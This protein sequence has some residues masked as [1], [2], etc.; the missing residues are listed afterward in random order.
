VRPRAVLALLLT[1]AGGL[2]GCGLQA[3]AG[4]GEARVLV[5]RDFGAHQLGARIEQQVP[6]SETV[7]R[8]LERGFHVTTRDGDRVVT[9][10]DGL[11]GDWS[12]TVNGVAST[13]GASVHGGDRVWWDR[14]HRSAPRHVTAV[15]GSFPEPLLHGSGGKRWPVVLQCADDASAACAIVAER[16]AA[17]GVQA[18][19]QTL[20]TGVG[21]DTLRVVV[22]PW[23][24]VAGDAALGQI[25]RGPAASGVSAR[26]TAGGR[27]L[28]LL[29][30]GGAVARTL[31][32][33]GGLLA[34]TRYGEQAPTWAVTGTDVAGVAA[35]ARALREARLARSFALALGPAG[36]TALPLAR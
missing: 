3:G 10:I 22:A 4:D 13:A 16:L 1:L 33:G 34:A 18:P 5:T 30:V 14:H 29:D 17:A 35:A 21:Q 7:L 31:G 20:A 8:M 26:F 15:V 24:E 19:R 28:E 11:A 9:S 27:T 12:V 6:G 2:A 23:R 36:A 32:A 25:D